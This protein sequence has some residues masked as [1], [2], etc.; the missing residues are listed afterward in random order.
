MVQCCDRP[1]LREDLI[2]SKKLPLGHCMLL[3]FETV[4]LGGQLRKPFL[5]V[6]NSVFQ[7]LPLKL[8]HCLSN[9]CVCH[10]LPFL[11]GTFSPVTVIAAS[12][13]VYLHECF[14][15]LAR[16]GEFF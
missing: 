16:Q 11:R 10:V 3:D 5:A 4:V 1:A 9:A 15:F 13:D 2:C 12:L 6:L 14:H 7:E 8:S